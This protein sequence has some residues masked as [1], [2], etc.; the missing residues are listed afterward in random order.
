MEYSHTRGIL[1]PR[2]GIRMTNEKE[3][4][5][6]NKVKNSLPNR[7]TRPV[8]SVVIPVFNGARYLVDAVSSVQKSTYKNFEVILI[9]DGSTDASRALCRE[10]TRK[11]KNVRFYDFPRNRGL[12]RVLNFALKK[13]KGSYI[14]RLN[15]DDK[16]LPHRLGTQISYLD[17]HPEIVALGSSIKLFDNNNDHEVIK[18]LETDS[19]IKSVWHI[20]SPFSDPSVMYRKEVAIAAGGYDQAFWPADDTQL[21]YRMGMRGQLANLTKPVVNVRWHNEAASV[22]FFKI[23]AKKT[24]E[25]HLWADE[26][27]EKAP[28]YVHVYWICQY[29]AG[30]TIPPQTNWKIYRVIKRIVNNEVHWSERLTE[31]FRPKHR[32]RFAI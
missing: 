10:L 4:I 28:W 24:L 29:I 6:K 16:M 15:Q 8:V 3:K 26:N 32:T 22:K 12:G 14:C 30:M 1:L 21:W 13:A 18:F 19:E 25:M 9:N 31:Y 7:I 17:K 5:M 2:S 11:Y 27:V 20:V 23:L